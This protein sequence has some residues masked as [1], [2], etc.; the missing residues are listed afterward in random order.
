MSKKMGKGG[1]EDFY[2]PMN[3]GPKSG[4][5]GQPTPANVP[6]VHPPDPTGVVPGKGK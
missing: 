5:K 1:Y 3:V 4:D 6:V 2:T